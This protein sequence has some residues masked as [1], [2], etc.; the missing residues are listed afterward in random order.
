[1]RM[2]P[3]KTSRGPKSPEPAPADAGISAADQTLFREALGP[4]RMIEAT[5][6]LPRRT[7][8][9]PSARMS[10]ADERA[11]VDELLTHPLDGLA[12]DLGDPLRYLKDGVAPRLL[13]QLGRGAY[14]VRDEFDLHQMT[15]AVARAA[16]ARFLDEC[17]REERLCV[18][19][20]HGKGLRSGSRG[21]VLKVLVDQL[22]RRRGDVLAFRSAQS[23]DG[24]S[25]VVIVLLRARSNR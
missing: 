4:V 25:G 14:A 6:A 16:L 22:L 24:G 15:V 2:P 23:G 1:M 13:R 11:V 18:R 10:E 9:A 8:P 19:I 21:P 20:V 3:R 7:P 12:L 17:V 5:A